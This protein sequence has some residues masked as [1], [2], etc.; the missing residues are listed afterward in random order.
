M[1]KLGAS[2]ELLPPELQVVIARGLQSLADLPTTLECKPADVYVA[3][4]QSAT[5]A[6]HDALARWARLLTLLARPCGRFVAAL[7]RALTPTV[8]RLGARAAEEAAAR[9]QAAARLLA[10]ALAVALALWARRALLARGGVVARARRRAA[11]ARAHLAKQRAKLAAELRRRRALLAGAA[12]AAAP[13]A[14]FFA[15]CAAAA[16]AAQAL[17]RRDG[18]AALCGRATPAVATALPAARTLLALG[19]AAPEEAAAHWLRYWV[20]WACVRLAAGAAMSVPLLPWLLDLA[21]LPLRDELPCAFWV[22]LHLPHDG[23]RVL[24]LRLA[25]A[26]RRR[27]AALAAALPAV[28]APVLA[29]LQIAA[30]TVLPAARRAQA[31]DLMRE[32]GVLLGGVIFL[33]TPSAITR[34][35]LLAFGLGYP[36]LRSL[37]ALDAL[38]AAAGSG[39]GALDAARADVG[40]R[41]WYWLAHAALVAAIGFLAPLLRWLPLTTHLQLLIVL[42][43][44]LPYFRHSTIALRRLLKRAPPPGADADATPDGGARAA[45][46]NALYSARLLRRGGGERTSPPS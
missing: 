40:G 34:L 30:A 10:L 21:P 42:W 46:S 13:H 33:M 14:A 11:A 6:T 22:W 24:H 38:A 37:D 28:P 8:L 44:Q 25:D 18:L 1:L 20:V 9:P 5:A 26:L 4:F 15:G 29:A 45:R 27:A 3:A 36:A 41:L 17:G 7:A 35:G 16:R 32:G 2:F 39:G 12:A 43:L 23:M 19:A 31:G